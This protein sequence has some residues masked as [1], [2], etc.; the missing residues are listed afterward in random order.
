MLFCPFCLL[1]QSIDVPII[2]GYDAIV[3]IEFRQKSRFL[4]G[5]CS[6]TNPQPLW[7]LLC[8]FPHDL[9]SKPSLYHHFYV[10]TTLP[11]PILTIGNR[12]YFFL[13]PVLEMHSSASRIVL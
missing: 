3:G 4:I 10:N 1:V 2:A 7:F 9:K 12:C 5:R 11:V 8:I 6:P 13:T